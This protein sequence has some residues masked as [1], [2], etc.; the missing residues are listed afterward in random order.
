MLS[1]RFGRAVV[2]APGLGLAAL[3][4]V[5]LSTATTL[6]AFLAVAV[7]YGLAFAA[8]QPA[9]MA[10]VVDRA[11]PNR[12]GAAMGTFSMAMDLGIGLGSIVWGVVAQAAGYQAMYLAASV[13]ALVA[14]VVF[15]VGWRGQAGAVSGS[16]G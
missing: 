6:T 3:G 4:L 9:M 7:L 1:D 13:V 11:A 14:L 5:V 2:I 16:R 12:R 8:A 10:L 15:V